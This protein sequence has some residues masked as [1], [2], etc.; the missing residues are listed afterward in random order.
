MENEKY[1]SEERYQEN[2]KKLKS[3]GKILLIIGVVIL[4]ISFILIGLGFAGFGST[5]SSGAD[6]INSGS[7]DN[8]QMAKGMFGSFGLFAIG[9]LINSVGFLL[10][11]AGGI[12][13]FVAHRREI[14]AYTTQQVMPVA[15]EGI[16]KITPTVANAAGEIAKSVSENIRKN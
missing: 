7:I 12:V 5:V 4:I 15:Q 13:M 8:S 16:E 1:L 10:T 11:V 3:V 14:A 6:A 9:G 2:N